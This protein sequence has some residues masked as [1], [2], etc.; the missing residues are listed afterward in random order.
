MTVNALLPRY[1]DFYLSHRYLRWI[2]IY[3]D[4]ENG[5]QNSLVRNERLDPYYGEGKGMSLE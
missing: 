3:K 4:G 2:H 1:G 5:S